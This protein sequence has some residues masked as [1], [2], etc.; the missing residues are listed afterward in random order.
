MFSNRNVAFYGFA[1][2]LTALAGCG[3]SGSSDAPGT[4]G[5][6]SA[7]DQTTVGQITGFGSIYVNGIEF[8]T[9]GAS[10]EVDDEVASDDDA[11][12]VG[13]VVKVEGSVNADGLTGTALKVEYDD[14]I[15]GVVE[16]LGPGE[17]TSEKIFLVMGVTVVADASGTNFRSD[18]PSFSFETIAEKDVVEVSGDYGT[19]GSLYA[20]YIEEQG[21]DDNEYEAK[22]TISKLNVNG[23]FDLTLPN[24]ST[25][26]VTLAA[27]A[28][29]PS[30]PIEV[31][32]F[33]EVEGTIDDPA[34]DPK[35]LAAS[36]V[37]LEDDDRLDDDDNEVEVKG[38][39]NYAMDTGTWS[40]KGI[41]LEFGGGTEYKPVSLKDMI[42]D[43]SATGMTVEVEGNKVG[44]VLRVEEIELEEDELE[45]KADVDFKVDDS[46]PDNSAPDSGTLT[47]SFGEADGVV[48]VIVNG[49]TMFRD[50][51][52]V[53]S[54]NYASI[55]PGDKVEI[56]ARWGDD[57]AIYASNLHLEDGSDYEIEGPVEEVDTDAGTLKVLD[58]VYNIDPN[59]TVF[60]DGIP[61]VGDFVEVED[62][63]GDGMADTVEIED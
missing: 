5:T 16:Q 29:L 48:S 28:E 17:D 15:E 44:E 22:G 59:I 27:G 54:F 33:V 8:D 23:G 55:N 25:L 51:D 35:T 45:F 60:E 13:M 24:N 9:V 56:D 57:G 3:G 62:E 42:D 34:A 11:L 52:A 6:P 43:R 12:A 18:D 19:D 4:P 26:V 14:D 10:Y 32:Q 7:T 47:L 53:E 21:A 40:V 50:D 58:V 61:V 37:E 38:M 41:A 1:L 49:D 20:T 39:L 46:T 30:V 2:L 63:T 31:G 36:K